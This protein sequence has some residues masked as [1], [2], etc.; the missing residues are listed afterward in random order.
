MIDV[1]SFGSCGFC[2]RSLYY[3]NE[4]F[5]SYDTGEYYC[6]YDCC[7]M[8]LEEKGIIKFTVYKAKET[9]ER[10][11]YWIYEYKGKKYRLHAYGEG[12]NTAED[13][14]DKLVKEIGEEVIYGLENE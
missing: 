3:E 12:D 8:G 7:I 2:K 1:E 11:D 5:K 4:H 13:E 10:Y 14:T 9:G 6:D